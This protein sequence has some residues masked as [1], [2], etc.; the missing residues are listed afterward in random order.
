MLIDNKFNYESVEDNPQNIKSV[1]NFIRHYADKD[2]NLH[3]RLD[4]VTGFF[5][6]AGLDILH[7]EMSPENHYRLILAELTVSYPGK[8]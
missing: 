4:I 6:I 1:W 7:R 8:S 5:S 2:K 3:G